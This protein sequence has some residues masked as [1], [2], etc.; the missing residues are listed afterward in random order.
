MEGDAAVE[1]RHAAGKSLLA[2]DVDDIFGKVEG[3]LGQPLDAFVLGQDERPF[4]FQHQRAGRHRRYNVIALVDVRHETRGDLFRR[5]GHFIDHALFEL[6]HAAA[7]GM[8]DFRLDAV[9]GEHGERRH[10]DRRVVIVA[11]AGGVE[12]GLARFRGR[13]LIAR[14]R[15]GGG[16][17][18]KRLAG[19][20]RQFGVAID[21]R[22][23]LF[24][25][26]H[27]LVVAARRPIDRARDQRRPFTVSIGVG[28]R[29]IGGGHALLLRLDRAIAQDEMRKVDIEFMRR[30]IGALRHEAHVAERAGV[31]DFLEIRAGDGVEFA[32]LRLVD[33]VEQPRKGIA[34]IETAPAGMTDIEHPAHFGVELRLVIEIGAAP[35]QRMPDRSLET[36]FSHDGPVVR[37]QPSL[38]GAE[39]RSNPAASQ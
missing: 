1:R 36:A 18:L 6:R 38:R 35:I 2:G 10:A 29:T 14:R 32:A 37:P 16:L 34:Q 19:V 31:H 17:R 11:V 27:R 12:H 26:A 21:A 23:L 13:G 7:G 20:C 8:H 24:E 5:L 33:E 30:H 39:R 25:I 4:E 9:P 28:E 15:V 22:D 3:R